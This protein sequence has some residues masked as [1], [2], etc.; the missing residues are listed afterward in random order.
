MSQRVLIGGEETEIFQALDGDG[1]PIIEN[2]LPLYITAGGVAVR[3]VE[4][5]EAAVPDPVAPAPVPVAPAPVPVPGPSKERAEELWPE[6]RVLFL[7]E[8]FKKYQ[9]DIRNRKKTKREVWEMLTKSI[10]E[11]FNCNMA[12]TQIENKWRALEKYRA[13]KQHNCMSGSDRKTCDF[14]E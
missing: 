9:S 8:L 6:A 4:V 7:I 1:F 11:R 13:T 2:G 14:E 12:F 10:N 3:L 5:T